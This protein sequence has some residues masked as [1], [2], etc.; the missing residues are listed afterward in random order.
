MEPEFARNPLRS[1]SSQDW[2][3]LCEAI[4]PP[5]LLALIEIRMSPALSQ[6][7]SAED[8][9]QEVLF[10]AWRDRLKIEWRG[11]RSFRAW[12][13]KAIENRTKDAADKCL[14]QKRGGRHRTFEF[15]SLGTGDS[16]SGFPGPDS[17]TTPSRS[18]R[19]RE[20]ARAIREA[21]ETLP[22]DLST[23]VRFRLLEQKTAEVVAEELGLSVSAV[24]R[25]FRK[26]LEMYS[27]QLRPLVLS[28]SARR[29]A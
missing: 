26:G 25:R 24:H 27:R 16:S 11:I 29:E 2:A 22:S 1:E 14:A 5:S 23:I 20:Q 19:R 9:L 7:Q 28:T 6:A 10:Q 21:L 17:S 3:E 8:I 4:H 15:S 12:V 13:V 18:A